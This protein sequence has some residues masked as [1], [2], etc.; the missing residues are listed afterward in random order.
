MNIVAP[1]FSST[2]SP[3]G[4]EKGELQ[5]PALVQATLPSG[6]Q[7][8]IWSYIPPALIAIHCMKNFPCP[9]ETTRA[10]ASSSLWGGSRRSSQ[11]HPD[12]GGKVQAGKKKT[13]L[14]PFI[15][16]STYSLMKNRCVT[17]VRGQFT[18]QNLW[19]LVSGTSTRFR[20]H[21]SYTGEREKNLNRNLKIYF[22]QLCRARQQPDHRLPR[23]RGRYRQ[24]WAFSTRS[25]AS[26]G[27][28]ESKC[29]H[30][31]SDN[32]V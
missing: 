21:T 31:L 6:F 20:A 9:V 8:L 23:P 15:L 10:S 18:D 28:K 29:Q 19:T 12:Q 27:F 26:F 14:K 17:M 4:G 30:D 1:V 7:P 13:S 32:A 11:V 25:E 2:I 3:P 24:R 22:I 16:P 5:G